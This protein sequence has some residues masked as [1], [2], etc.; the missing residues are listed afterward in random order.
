MSK[1]SSNAI[2]SAQIVLHNPISKTPINIFQDSEFNFGTL[3]IQMKANDNYVNKEHIHI[4][5]TID[6]SGSMSDLCLD[7]RSKMQ[8]ILYTLQNM[9]KIFHEKKEIPISIYIQSFNSYVKKIVES[10]NLAEENIED[11]IKKIYTISPNG[12]TNIE[13]ALVSAN[14]HIKLYKSQYPEHNII[15]LFMTDGEITEGEKKKS[16]LKSIIQENHTTTF[17]GYGMEHDSGLL[18]YLA[19]DKDNQY[20]FIDALEKAGLVYGE[21]IHGILY[22]ALSKVSLKSESC[23][24]YNF[25][26]NEWTND[27]YIGDLLIEQKK[28]FHIRTKEKDINIKIYKMNEDGKEYGEKFG[29]ELLVKL[30]NEK[31]KQDLSEYILRQRTQELL[32]E[33]KTISENER[34]NLLFPVKFPINFEDEMKMNEQ[35]IKEQNDKKKIMKNKLKDFLYLIENY[36]KENN[37]ESDPFLKNLTDDIYI[38][39]ITFGTKHAKM[40]TTARQTSQGLQQAYN[41]LSLPPVRRS[42]P[43]HRNRNIYQFDMHSQ[44]QNDEEDLNDEENDID[45]YC[46]SQTI[47]TPYTSPSVFKVMR[48]VTGDDTLNL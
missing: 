6:N 43:R 12:C 45:K 26:T 42:R 20:R 4:I 47:V 25:L 36:M 9:L 10:Q 16:I 3:T 40:Y 31:E 41:C 14:K 1:V 13:E 33:V 38:S 32:Y 8:H 46:L 2:S 28:V 18:N 22:K 44:L 48:D 27:L 5:F 35:L 19:S 30:D 23:E 29:E 17:I 39:Y 21:I 24:I 7:N 34:E 15:H 11:I 37:K